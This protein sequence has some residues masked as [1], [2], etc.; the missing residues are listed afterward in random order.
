MKVVF[1]VYIKGKFNVHH[2]SSTDKPF[3]KQM[4]FSKLERT[5]PHLEPSSLLSKVIVELFNKILMLVFFP[6]KL[7]A[8]KPIAR[9]VIQTSRTAYFYIKHAIY[10]SVFVLQSVYSEIMRMI[11]VIISTV[12]A[13][14]HG[15]LFA[16]IQFVVHLS[17]FAMFVGCFGLPINFKSR[18]TYKQAHL[19]SQNIPYTEDRQKEHML[20]VYLVAAVDEK[21]E[22]HPVVIFLQGSSWSFTS[23]EIYSEIGLTFRRYGFVTI[24]PN[25]ATFPKATI[26]GMVSEVGE[27]VDWTRKNC[28]IYGGNPNE[29]Y[30]IGSSSGAHLMLSYLIK[31]THNLSSSILTFFSSRCRLQ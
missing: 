7:P 9:F 24:I 10:W 28:S 2:Q 14:F 21:V 27:I 23:K 19:L 3:S 25:Y 8:V 26:G 5:L 16:P 12:V 1:K 4:E 30:L 13:A 6:L 15:I 22:K 29:I 17:Q 11:T 31:Q 18:R 20:D